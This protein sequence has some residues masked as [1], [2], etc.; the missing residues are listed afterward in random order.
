M[1]QNK[2]VYA[3]LIEKIIWYFTRK[4]ILGKKTRIKIVLISC[5]NYKIIN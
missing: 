3:S 5:T 1:E 4:I 2:V